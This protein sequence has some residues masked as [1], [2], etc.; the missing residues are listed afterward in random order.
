MDEDDYL[1]KGQD[2][3]LLDRLDALYEKFD[4]YNK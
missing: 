2:D 3:G 1:I 4:I